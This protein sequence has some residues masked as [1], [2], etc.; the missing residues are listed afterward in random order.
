MRF[1]L[2]IVAM[3]VVVVLA[4]V[5]A[6]ALTQKDEAPPKPAPQTAPPAPSGGASTGVSFTILPPR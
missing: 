4:A 5:P 3:F 1:W 2:H 6:V